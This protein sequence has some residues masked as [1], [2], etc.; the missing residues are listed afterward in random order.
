MRR[1]NNEKIASKSKIHSFGLIEVLISGVVLIT[2]I[3]ATASVRQRTTSQSS[4]SRH[5]EVATMLAQEG[6]EAVHQIRDTNYLIQMKDPNTGAIVKVPW[7]CYLLRH[8]AQAEPEGTDAV[9]NRE[10]NRLTQCENA[11][12]KG[13]SVHS[14]GWV[15]EVPNSGDFSRTSV[16]LNGDQLS[17]PT[18]EISLNTQASTYPTDA[19]GKHVRMNNFNLSYPALADASDQSMAIPLRF[20]NTIVGG[21]KC[22]GVE[23]IFVQEGSS[24]RKRAPN[25]V[26]R[27]VVS[28]NRRW[29]NNSGGLWQDNYDDTFT[30]GNGCGWSGWPAMTEFH[31]QVAISPAN[32]AFGAAPLD[33]ATKSNWPTEWNSGVT[34]DHFARVLV[35]VSWNE[36]SRY[37]AGGMESAVMFATYLTDWR[38]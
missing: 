14:M 5:E 27:F 31:R 33:D 35:R 2:I 10:T 20:D 3:S 25:G 34:P 32:S 18:A 6:I 4:Y 16:T 17:I 1:I 30:M 29:N 21:D 22:I 15:Y 38:P 37:T 13:T 11:I 12:W 28:A 9:T 8:S 26:W 19:S 23:R 24:A 36:Q 7:D